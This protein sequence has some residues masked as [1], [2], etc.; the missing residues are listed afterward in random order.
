MVAGFSS[1]QFACLLDGMTLANCF[2][3]D[4]FRAALDEYI[5]LGSVGGWKRHHMMSRVLFSIVLEQPSFIVN[6][7]PSWRSLISR[8]KPTLEEDAEQPYH[9]TL[10]LSARALSLRAQIRKRKGPYVV[11]LHV[12][13]AMQSSS[14]LVT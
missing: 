2:H 8:A 13:L 6:A 4:L 9:E 7:P 5:R 1:K 12:N 11:D 3:E 14:D 10:G